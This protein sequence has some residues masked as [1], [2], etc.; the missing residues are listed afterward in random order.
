MMMHAQIASFLTAP[1][2]PTVQVA[3]DR[4]DGNA[5]RRLA[6][7]LDVPVPD[8]VP[9]L[10]H[11]TAFLPDAATSRLM[12]DGHP[13]RGGLLPPLRFERR[14]FAGGRLSFHQPLYLDEP[15]RR[16]SVVTDVSHKHGRSGEL[17]FV[18]LHHTVESERGLLLE[19]ANSLVYRDEPPRQHV[20]PVS[21]SASPEDVNRM[22]V[23]RTT[24]TTPTLLFRYSALT[25]NAHRIHYDERYAREVEDYPGLVVHGPLLAT[26]LAGTLEEQHDAALATFRFRG[27]SPAFLGEPLTFHADPVPA[28][29]GTVRALASVKGRAVMSATATLRG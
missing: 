19:E 27:V 12:A 28:A 10:W 8:N 11:W 25:F 23:R 14:M 15:L 18:T 2:E 22:P 20:R 6:A 24:T 9:A 13:E 3:E 4:V 17:A 21:A 29:D 1:W 7:T 5:I 16:T 26:W